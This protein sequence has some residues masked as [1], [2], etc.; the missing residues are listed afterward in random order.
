[1]AEGKRVVVTGATGLIGRPLC[2]ALQK[3]GYAVV[4][5]SRSPDSA[6]RSLPGMAEYVAWKP[7]E[8]GPW[9]AA[10]DGAHAV[11]HLGAANLFEKRWNTAFKREIVD[12]RV[13]GTRGIVNAI[14]A[15][16]RKPEV[17][18][19]ASAVGYYGPR[20]SELLDETAAPGDD[21]QARVCKLWE[22]EAVKA[23][24]LGV[25][26]VRL[27]SGVVLQPGEGALAQLMLPF[28]F[29]VGG[30]VLP[31]TQWLSW[32][33]LADEVGIIL[34]ALEDSA[35]SGSLNATAP[36]PATNAEFARTL[37]RVMRRPSLF[38]VP[39]FAVRLVVGEVASAVT[40]GQ[41]V[42]PKKA[43]DHGYTFQFPTVEL[44][45]R[46]LLQR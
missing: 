41:Y 15:A 4:V 1:M 3:R 9:A 12:S 43:L 2:A 21:F 40:N 17:L 29:F 22:A 18:I 28:K 31:G 24:P 16:Q 34:G 25:R 37:G 38:P 27:R 36:Q 30:P 46:D 39:G 11:I 44:A 10:V 42:V 23:E 26:V 45:L 32:I 14:V 35:I 20:Q 8:R 33:H 19:S 13:S 5:F 7:E 6:R